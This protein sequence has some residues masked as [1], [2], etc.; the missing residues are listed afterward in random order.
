VDEIVAAGYNAN[1]GGPAVKVEIDQHADHSISKGQLARVSSSKAREA[2]S[3]RREQASP[4]QRHRSWNKVLSV[5]DLVSPAWYVAVNYFR[6]AQIIICLNVSRCEV[7]FDYGLRQKRFKKLEQRP[8]SFT[9]AEG[10]KIVVEKKVAAKNDRIVKRGRVRTIYT[11]FILVINS[12]LVHSQSTR[13]SRKRSTRWRSVWM[14][15]L[16]KNAGH[17][18][19]CGDASLLASRLTRLIFS[20]PSLVNMLSGIHTLMTLGCTVRIVTW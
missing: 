15:P 5:S 13:Y 4:F 2:C 18:G 14:L 8:A 12:A 11:T 1:R 10:K 17:F 7:Q 19:V 16:A 6:M 20:P 9:S 3:T